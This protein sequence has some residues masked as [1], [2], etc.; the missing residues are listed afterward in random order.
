MIKLV[1]LVLFVCCVD[2]VFGADREFG[3]PPFRTFTARDYGEV[4]QIFAIGQDPEGRML[5]GCED[6]ILV[7]DNNR[8]ETTAT[9]GAGFIRSLDSVAIKIPLLRS[10][11]RNRAV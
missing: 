7:F 1:G 11:A 9:P 4:G 8:W 3:H 2:V 10:W 6:R 5:F